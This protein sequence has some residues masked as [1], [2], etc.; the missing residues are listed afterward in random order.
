MTNIETIVISKNGI[1]DVHTFRYENDALVFFVK[2]AENLGVLLEEDDINKAT[3][4]NM[5]MV[6][7]IRQVDEHLEKSGNELRW[8]NTPLK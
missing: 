1:L 4:D 5:T 6:R 7:I 8:F 3:L 2:T